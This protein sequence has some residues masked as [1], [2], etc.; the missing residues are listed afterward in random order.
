MALQHGD[1]VLGVVR[2][3][4]QLAVDQEWLQRGV[5]RLRGELVRVTSRV[6]EWDVIPLGRTDPDGDTDQVGR[7]R[8]ERVRLDVDGVA[9]GLAHAPHQPRQILVG[10]HDRAD[11]IRALDALSDLYTV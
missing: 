10:A 2:V 8:I 7:Q 5:D 6:A 11:R 4:L 1:V 9:T 3:R